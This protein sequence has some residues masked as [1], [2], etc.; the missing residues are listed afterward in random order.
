MYFRYILHTYSTGITKKEL[1]NVEIQEQTAS[2]K[3][4]CGHHE[5]SCE[6]KQLL[7]LRVYLSGKKQQ[8]QNKQEAYIF[9]EVHQQETEKMP[10]ILKRNNMLIYF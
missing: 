1:T 3:K 8:K 10:T 4:K 5:K 2:L 6:F 9:I 7:F